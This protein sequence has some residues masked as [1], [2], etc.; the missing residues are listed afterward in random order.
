MQ[1]LKPRG[2]GTQSGYNTLRNAEKRWEGSSG[3]HRED[4]LSTKDAQPMSW[5]GEALNWEAFTIPE[6]CGFS[7]LGLAQ[8]REPVTPWFDLPHY[9]CFFFSCQG[10]FEWG[11]DS[12]RTI[13]CPSAPLHQ[14]TT[15][16]IY[17]KAEHQWL[18]P[19]ILAI[20]RW[21]PG[22]LRFEASLGK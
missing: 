14:V 9:K 16:K 3:P 22:G 11:R 20:R 15:S 21:R 1:T 7:I 13:P 18:T 10:P 2:G 5:P 19:V 4:Q 12:H 8:T 17:S 6:P